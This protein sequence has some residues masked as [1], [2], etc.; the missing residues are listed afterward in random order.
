MQR[1]SIGRQVTYRSKTGNY[2]L[3]ATIT[4]TV[5]TLWEEGVERGDVPALSSPEHVHLHVLTPGAA[6]QYQEHDV[7]FSDGAGVPDAVHGPRT[8]RWPERV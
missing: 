8:W 2:D 6:V 5:D 7:P 4:A 1:P 3:T